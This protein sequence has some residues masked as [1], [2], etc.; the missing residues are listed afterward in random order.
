MKGLARQQR[1]WVSSPLGFILAWG[2]PMAALIVGIF[3]APPAKIFIWFVP[4]IWMGAACLAN[5][6]RC[7]RTHCMFTGPF[8][9]VMAVLVILHGF[10]IVWLGPNGW[11]WLGLTMAVGAGGLWVLTE[12]AWGRFING[13]KAG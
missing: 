11:T 2:L 8:F 1:D 10:E 6:R 4:L 7:G 3:I 13:G 9:L 12:K 5:A